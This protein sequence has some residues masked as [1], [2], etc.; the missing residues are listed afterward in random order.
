MKIELL[1]RI[2]TFV[3]FLKIKF[4]TLK[5][6]IQVKSYG[7]NP[8]CGGPS[9]FSSSVIMGDNCNFNG[10]QII[11]LGEVIIGNN[12]HSGTE[13]MIVTSNH[14]YDNDSAIPYGH[15]HIKKKIIIDDNVW[16][17]NR[18]LVTGNI[19]IGEGA[20]I[21]AGSVVV[22]DVEPLS[23]VGGNPAKHIKFRDRKHYFDLKNAKSFH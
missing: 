11:G 17:G 22:K 16:F 7:R 2:T 4:Y 9:S 23:I 15:N 13:C 20:I 21:A 10:M 18:V 19:R 14:D 3:K 12:F 6:K 8:Y 5:L 1:K